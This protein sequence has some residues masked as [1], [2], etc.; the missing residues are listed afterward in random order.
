M[1]LKGPTRNIAIAIAVVA[2]LLAATVVTSV[3]R[4]SGSNNRYKQALDAGNASELALGAKGALTLNVVFLTQY[5]LDQDPADLTEA[6]R[7]HRV[8]DLQLHRLTAVDP[9]QAALVERARREERRFHRIGIE[10]VVPAVG[11]SGVNAAIAKFEAAQKVTFGSLDRLE[12]ITLAEGEAARKKGNDTSSSASFLVL[13]IGV[14]AFVATLAIGF[15]VIRVVSSLLGHIRRTS[16]GLANTVGELQAATTKAASATSQQSSAV[17][18]VAS[19]AEQLNA[20]ASSI[21][22]NARAGSSAVDQTEEMMRGMQ[23]QVQAISERSLALGE[24][25]QKI[26][27]VLELINDIAEQTNLLALNA[28]IEAARAGDAG[29]GFAVVATEVRKLAERSLRSTEEIREIITSVQDETNATIMA[30][31][32]G[33][34]QAHEVGELMGSAAEVLDESLRA[35]E[36][37]KEAAQQVSAA[38]VQVRTSAEELSTEQGHRLEI[39]QH[40]QELAQRLER[41]L[42]EHG[43][44]RQDGGAGGNGARG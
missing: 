38:M 19:T 22:D 11:T 23:E 44:T 18:E 16:E 1:D 21:A 41:T 39:T 25:S 12:A 42:R 5:A 8:F 15:Y 20:T 27:E 34:K 40:V 14:L 13:L 31:E 17:A 2:L 7:V 4:F 36:Q 26:T 37:Q 29:K 43:L 10:E 3:W 28:A 9:D 6:A 35:T 32:Q 24:R 30:T 33:A